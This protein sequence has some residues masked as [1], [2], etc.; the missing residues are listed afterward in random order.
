MTHTTEGNTVQRWEKDLLSHCEP[1]YPSCLPLHHNSSEPLLVITI[2]LGADK[3]LSTVANIIF[4]IKSTNDVIMLLH[5]AA[6]QQ[7]KWFCILPGSE[8]VFWKEIFELFCFENLPAQRIFKTQIFFLTKN[9][10][11]S[12]TTFFSCLSMCHKCHSVTTKRHV[13]PILCAFY[14]RTPKFL[15]HLHSPTLKTHKWLLFRNMD[16]THNRVSIA[17]V[18]VFLFE[19]DVFFIVELT[20][21]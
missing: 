15:W 19:G 13:V 1:L 11:L 6:L 5:S 18:S 20:I 3:R 14:L 16:I 12:Q 8:K 9:I 2:F 21:V 7:G 4:Q 10:K 17:W